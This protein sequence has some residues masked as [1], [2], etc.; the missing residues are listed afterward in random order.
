MDYD[1]NDVTNNATHYQ[2]SNTV[3]DKIN[4][5]I[6]DEKAQKGRT[7]SYYQK[8]KKDNREKYLSDRIQKQMQ[9]DAVSL[10]EAF[11]DE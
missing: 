6:E 5:L 10:G 9:Q 11:F 3:Q 8:I 7:L 4:K 1:I 2:P